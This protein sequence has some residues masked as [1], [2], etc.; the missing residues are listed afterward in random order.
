LVKPVGDFC[1]R[2]AYAL[3][4]T[5]LVLIVLACGAAE[6]AAAT[7]VAAPDEPEAEAAA[8]VDAGLA[9]DPL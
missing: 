5:A 8:G 7:T 9:A 6:P 1:A 3:L 4:S 2:L